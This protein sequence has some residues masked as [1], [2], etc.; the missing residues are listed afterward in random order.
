MELLRSRPARRSLRHFSQT[1]EA[2]VGGVAADLAPLNLLFSLRI[3]AFT[4]ASHP[5]RQFGVTERIF[6]DIQIIYLG[7]CRCA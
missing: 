4:P 6:F 2:K 5:W 3:M 7:N 1:F